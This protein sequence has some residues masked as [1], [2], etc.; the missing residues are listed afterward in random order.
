MAVTHHGAN[1]NGEER[2][3]TDIKL[4]FISA[5]CEAFSLPQ[6]HHPQP[7][8][9][10]RPPCAVYVAEPEPE[11]RRRERNRTATKHDGLLLKEKRSPPL[12]K[13]RERAPAAALFLSSRARSLK[14]ASG[15]R[16]FSGLLGTQKTWRRSSTAAAVRLLPLLT[17]LL[18]TRRP[19]AS[20]SSPACSSATR[21]RRRCVYAAHRP[22]A[23][24][25]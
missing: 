19:R 3:N 18:T 8:H 25:F 14:L 12:S 6:T 2:E 5:W 10:H 7:K 15:P 9:K 23:A 17:P 20:R 21:S 16:S 22:S 4:P 11:Q 13:R 1:G 24:L